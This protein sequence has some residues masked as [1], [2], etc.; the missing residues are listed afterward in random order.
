MGGLSEGIHALRTTERLSAGMNRPHMA[1][2]LVLSLENC[3]TF[4][5]DRLIL[6]KK[7][8]SLRACGEETVG[9][10]ENKIWERWDSRVGPVCRACVLFW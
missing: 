6:E 2:H 5:T 7:L 8:E 9:R 4:W 1:F 10:D 3:R